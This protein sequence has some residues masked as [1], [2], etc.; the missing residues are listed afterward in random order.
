MDSDGDG[1][2]DGYEIT[3]G[4]DPLLSDS[5]GDGLSMDRSRVWVLTPSLMTPMAMA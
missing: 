4:T 1:L 2:S 3:T 5:D